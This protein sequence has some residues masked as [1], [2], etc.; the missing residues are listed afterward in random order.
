MSCLCSCRSTPEQKLSPEPVSMT[1]GNRSR[2]VWKAPSRAV[3]DAR[4]MAFRLSGL[5]NRM[6]A[7]FSRSSRR[8]RGSMSSTSVRRGSLFLEGSSTLDPVLGIAQKPQG[9][10]FHLNAGEERKVQ[11]LPRQLLHRPHRQGRVDRNAQRD[12]PR[13]ASEI[14]GRDDTTDEPDPQ[15]LL[16]IDAIAG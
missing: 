4:S 10:L 15:R 3:R 9:E 2:I 14:F 12:L 13:R 7:T 8:T 16:G 5:F 11:P 6:I 1:T